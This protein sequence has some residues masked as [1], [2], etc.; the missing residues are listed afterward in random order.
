MGMLGV[1]NADFTQILTDLSGTI[2]YQQFTGST[3]TIYGGTTYTFASDSTKSWVFF[4]RGSKIDLIKYGI[5]EQGDAYVIMPTTDSIV[6]R[7]RIVYNSEKFE[8]T[9]ECTEVLRMINGV[10]LFRYYTLKKVGTS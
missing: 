2:T 10:S 9:P 6:F 8:Y 3:D 7:D 4:K 1:S 5:I